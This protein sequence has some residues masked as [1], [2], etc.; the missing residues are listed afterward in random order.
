MASGS[1]PTS[2]EARISKPE[3]TETTVTSA[4]N[5]DPKEPTTADVV[6]IAEPTEKKPEESTLPKAQTDGAT[7]LGGGNTGIYE[8]DYEV[9]IKLSDAQ[10]DPNNPLFSV[11]TFEELGL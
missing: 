6:D 1:E 4:V 7:E 10:A 9:E 5:S 3:T 11:K 2:L 8:P